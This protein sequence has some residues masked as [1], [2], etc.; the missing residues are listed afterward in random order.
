MLIGLI[1]DS[2]GHADRVTQAMELLTSRGVECIIHLGDI[3]GKDVLDAMQGHEVRIVFGN[4][5]W[6]ERELQDHA[7]SIGIHV[8]HPIGRLECGGK[9]LA[10]THGHRDELMQVSLS[11][12]A[13]YLCHGHTHLVRD[14]CIQSTRVLNPGA[15]HAASRYTVGLLD[16]TADTFDILELDAVS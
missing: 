13:E 9:T 3:G 4:C 14:E 7:E 2:H 6:E 1:S 5:D 16:T 12:H 8:D 11:E 10:Y 15:L